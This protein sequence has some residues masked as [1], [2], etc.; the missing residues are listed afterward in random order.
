MP[1][2]KLKVMGMDFEQ[3][4]NKNST[5][6][7]TI[8]NYT[9]GVLWSSVGLFFLVAEKFGYEIGLKNKVVEIFFGITALCY[10]LFRI[11]RGYKKH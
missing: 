9:M 3:N 11:Y 1:P 8:Y 2:L 4:S 5:T 7:R 6:I 10:G